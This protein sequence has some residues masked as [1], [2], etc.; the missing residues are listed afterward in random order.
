MNKYFHFLATVVLLNVIYTSEVSAA[1]WQ[2]LEKTPSIETYYDTDSIIGSSN[3]KQITIKQNITE[4]A[5]DGVKSRTMQY[6]I[7]CI[8]KTSLFKSMVNY[9]AL[10]LGGVGNPVTIQ[11]N[12][13]WPIKPKSLAELFLKVACSSS[14]AEKPAKASALAPAEEALLRRWKDTGFAASKL[15][16]CPVNVFNNCFGAGIDSDGNEYVGE[17]RNN[18]PIG[19]LII[20]YKD[21]NRYVGEYDK[22]LNGEGIYYY[23]KQDDWRGTIFVGQFKDDI[24][25]GN[26]IYFDRNGGVIETGLYE[27]DNLIEYRFVDP[28]TF[29]RIPAGKIPS[30]SDDERLKIQSKQAE[31][32]K[33][34]ADKLLAANLAKKEEQERQ[35]QLKA[36]QQGQLA[37]TKDGRSLNVVLEK[38]AE[39]DGKYCQMYVS[40]ENNSSVNFSE[41][42]FEVLAK[43]AQDNIIGT[44]F[45]AGRLTP[46]NSNTF[47]TLVKDCNSIKKM[48]F[49]VK[50]TTQIDG[51]YIGSFG[52]REAEAY[53]SFPINASSKIRNVSTTSGTTTPS[54]SA[55]KTTTPNT[56]DGRSLNVV[57][58]KFAEN[59]GKYCQMYVSVENNSSVNFSE[60]IFEVLAK[61]AQDNIIG[62]LFFAGRLTPQ[63][64]NTFNTLVKDCNS[65]KKMHFTVKSTTQIDGKYI[66][67]FGAR[68]AEAYMSFPINASSKIR[69]VSTTSGTTTPSTS[70]P[71]TATV[72]GDPLDVVLNIN[73][74]SQAAWD[75][76]IDVGGLNAS[77]GNMLYGIEIRA[78][79]S[80]YFK[81]GQNFG[82]SY[83]E[84]RTTVSPA[85]M[86][87][88]LS[89]VCEV[90]ENDFIKVKN[91]SPAAAQAKFNRKG[92]DYTC[93]YEMSPN[94]GDN[95]M[96]ILA[97]KI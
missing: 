73:T 61:D 90:A 97:N 33:K 91:N 47:N 87:S 54:T 39:N 31:I 44:L 85:S 86:R 41:L 37:S 81:D 66:G 96:L 23:L 72:R 15:P 84:M 10:N 32:A 27:G 36:S 6:E 13:P 22:K 26:G 35:K 62:T 79:S 3:K 2:S 9:D 18:V 30:I 94:G 40:V 69:N 43:D 93:Y 88:V 12:P 58:E 52:A 56:K 65:I 48:H 75:A 71:S 82:P 20:T 64:S 76:W 67:S 68:E 92:I 55:P 50:S 38:F 51:K 46:Q 19:N 60:L 95:K 8:E 29:T 14:V 1:N 70:A 49:T 34:E 28:K 83:I 25:R 21:G 42:I 74:G 63:N 78:V 4:V 89:K 24:Q 7:D 45:F 59:D 16:F 11:A 53:M 5:N 77:N 57:L 80:K 17:F